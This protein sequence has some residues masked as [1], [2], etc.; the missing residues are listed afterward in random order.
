[1]AELE[2][3][4]PSYLNHAATNMGPGLGVVMKE[5]TLFPQ[6]DV[7]LFRLEVVQAARFTISTENLNDGAD[8]YLEL[9][10]S[11]G[12]TPVMLADGSPA[13]NDNHIY[14]V[15]R[16]SAPNNRGGVDVVERRW[17]DYNG[18]CG[19]ESVFL[20]AA[21]RT[22]VNSCPPNAANPAPHPN[23]AIPEYLSSE[24]TVDL[25]QG[26]YYIRVSRAP[27]APPSAGKYGGYDLRVQ[28]L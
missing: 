23:L 18:Q 21:V 16:V 8:T 27:G 22:T 4:A 12:T 10:E 14:W 20:G 25:A 19:R 5:H 28:G 2:A 1:M 13:V 9:F 7:D 11:D 6:G 3:Q 26:T 24:L 17:I 15:Q